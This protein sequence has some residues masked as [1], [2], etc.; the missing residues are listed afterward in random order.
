M[1]L[2]HDVYVSPLDGRAAYNVRR[3]RADREE[4][5]LWLGLQGHKALYE[6]PLDAWFVVGRWRLTLCNT[7]LRRPPSPAKIEQVRQV[8]DDLLATLSRL[9]IAAAEPRRH[10]GDEFPRLLHVHVQKDGH[11]RLS[12]AT[13]RIEQ[14]LKVTHWSGRLSYHF[15][16][17]NVES[18]W[19][20][21]G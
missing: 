4:Y 21:V 11:Q 2:L 17:D 5:V 18:D 10:N 14:L 12:S 19:E 1:E 8:A 13:N 6:R 7:R 20:L 15:S 3:Q 9:Q 16:Q